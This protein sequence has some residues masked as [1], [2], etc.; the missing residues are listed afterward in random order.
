MKLVPPPLTALIRPP[1][2]PFPLTKPPPLMSLKLSPLQEHQ[3]APKPA[4]LSYIRSSDEAEYPLKSNSKESRRSRRYNH[5]NQ[6]KQ[7][8]NRVQNNDHCVN[9]S[10]CILTK[11]ETSILGK[12][13]GFVPTPPIPHPSAIQKDMNKFART[14][15]ATLA[16][17]TMAAYHIAY[18]YIDLSNFC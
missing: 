6:H 3:L 10:S 17:A 9:L 16:T 14:L 5:N 13:L 18:L 15:I 2:P 1:L 4:P 8:P 11:E 12:G 7:K